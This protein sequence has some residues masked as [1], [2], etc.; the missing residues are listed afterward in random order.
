M[1]TQ[2]KSLP[3][4]ARKQFS[5]WDKRD[6]Y[7]RYLLVKGLRQAVSR[8]KPRSYKQR[9]KKKPENLS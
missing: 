1:V 4:V 2:G 5:D 6:T 8:R 7:E 9:R 3:Q